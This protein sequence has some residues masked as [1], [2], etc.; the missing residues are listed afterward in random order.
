MIENAL[1]HVTFRLEYHP[2]DELAIIMFCFS[3]VVVEGD[4]SVGDLVNGIDLPHLKVN[5]TIF[6]TFTYDMI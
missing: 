2:I 1:K 6:E 4:L 3:D 5:T